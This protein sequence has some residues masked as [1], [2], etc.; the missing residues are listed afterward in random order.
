MTL[1]R[2]H[3][4]NSLAHRITPINGARKLYTAKKSRY[5][6]LEHQHLEIRAQPK[7]YHRRKPMHLRYKFYHW[8]DTTLDVRAMCEGYHASLFIKHWP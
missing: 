1:A 8:I 4:I 2:E 6:C 7:K 5:Q 3:F